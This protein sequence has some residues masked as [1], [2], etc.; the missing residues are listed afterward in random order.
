MGFGTPQTVQRLTE[1]RAIELGG[2][3]LGEAFIFVTAAGG[4]TFEYYRYE[5][6]ASCYYP[7]C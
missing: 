3:I 6:S 4:L 7:V 5:S 2:D 1:E